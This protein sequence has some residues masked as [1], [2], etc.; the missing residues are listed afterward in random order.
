MKGPLYIR[1]SLF[2]ILKRVYTRRCKE[3]NASTTT[4]L[5]VNVFF[6]GTPI[7]LYK[8]MGWTMRL[9][10]LVIISSGLMFFQNCSGVNFDKKQQSDDGIVGLNT[11]ATDDLDS[12]IPE[13][14][15]GG[16]I[17]GHFD[18]DTSSKIYDFSDG[19]TDRHIH[20]YDDKFDVT[21]VD[22]F[23]M[24]DDK[25]GEI[26]EVVQANSRFAIIVANANLSP[27]AIIEVNGRRQ[28]AT[29]Y[30]AQNGN[31][32]TN[33][34]YTLGSAP[35]HLKLTSLKVLFKPDAIIN[36]GL[37]PTQTG[38]VRDND[39]GKQNEYRNGALIVQA[40][41]LNS[42]QIDPATGTASSGLLWEATVFWHKDGAGCY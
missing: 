42:A 1:G 12:G 32:A 35:G 4:I 29:E 31:L 34:K 9:V 36:G 7:A 5:P 13:T 10:I 39:P 24:L 3:N 30:Q 11:P 37:I 40:I 27:G 25:L 2:P 28:L 19:D 8:P 38:C 23:G 17:G 26:N 15:E 16:L 20:E 21:Y 14:I 33:M 18:L 41:D 22:F 6:R